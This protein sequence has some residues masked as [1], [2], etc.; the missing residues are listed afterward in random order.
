VPELAEGGF[1]PS[2]APVYS[3]WGP[4]AD[5]HVS[6]SVGG[7][8]WCP[9]FPLI[10]ERRDSRA[11]R[12]AGGEDLGRGRARCALPER[13]AFQATRVARRSMTTANLSSLQPP[14]PHD[15]RLVYHPEPDPFVGGFCSSAGAGEWRRAPSLGA[16]GG[17]LGRA[18]GGNKLRAASIPNQ[19]AI[20]VSVTSL[21]R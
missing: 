2:W 12:V 17:V 8:T 19:A 1:P 7:C 18:G 5:P 15:D 21:R 13:L 3:F 16:G 9:V 10:G 14:T 4:E 6:R 11:A 20:A